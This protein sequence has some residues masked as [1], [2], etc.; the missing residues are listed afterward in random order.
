MA[1]VAPVA[2]KP[3]IALTAPM[4]FN[5]TFTSAAAASSTQPFISTISKSGLPSKVDF[6]RQV[7][8][9]DIEVPA[10]N[11]NSVVK[12]KIRHIISF[13]LH[14]GQ[15]SASDTQDSSTTTS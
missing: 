14:D 9:K 4:T 3:P 6:S 7:S 12:E 10:V 11:S 5:C 8:I 15:E 2:P 1:P 13:S